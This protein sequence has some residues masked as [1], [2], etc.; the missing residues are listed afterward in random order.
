MMD[1]NIFSHLYW[2][3]ILCFEKADIRM[4]FHKNCEHLYCVSIIYYRYVIILYNYIFI[5]IILYY[6]NIC[7]NIY[8]LYLTLMDQFKF[9][10]KTVTYNKIQF[11]GVYLKI[12]KKCLSSFNF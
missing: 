10:W 4:S 7:I 2:L 12:N 3:I 11:N 5:L 1:F 8:Y 9:L 6:K